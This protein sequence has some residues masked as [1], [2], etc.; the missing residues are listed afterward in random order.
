MTKPLP[1]AAYELLKSA[2]D[3]RFK[4]ILKIVK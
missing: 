1:E 3:D 4:D 2:K